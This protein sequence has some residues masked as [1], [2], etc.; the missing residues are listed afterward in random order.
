MLQGDSCQ[1][2]PETHSAAPR[3]EDAVFAQHTPR[4]NHLLAALRAWD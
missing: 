4:Q 1:L 3:R 2:Y